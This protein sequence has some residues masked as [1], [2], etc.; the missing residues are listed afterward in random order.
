MR[1]RT[2]VVAVAAA[3]LAG[4]GTAYADG[5]PVAGVT[6]GGQGVSS[7]S[8]RYVAL[9]AP[10]GTAVAQIDESSGTVNGFVSLRG[11]WGIP[12]VAF[13]GATAGISAGG[14]TLVLG[15]NATT[16][17]AKRTRFAL[18]NPLKMRL[19]RIVSLPGAFFFDAISPDG[20]TMYLIQLTSR[21]NLLRY[22]VRA[23]DLGRDRLV[24]GAVVDKTE[25]DERMAGVPMARAATSDGVWAYTLYYK[26]A[27]G[28]FVHALNTQAGVA[29]CI[30]LPPLSTQDTPQ[31]SVDGGRLDVVSEGQVLAAV[32]RTTFAVTRSPAPVPHRSPTPA[33]RRP[34]AGRSSGGAPVWAAI[35]AGLVLAG[36][37][38]LAVRRR[39]PARGGRSGGAAAG[40]P[41]GP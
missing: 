23:Y 41:S 34:A 33:K 6:I 1:I 35:P 38:I 31:L 8:L 40:A 7:G 15:R 25:P 14:Q 10:G 20:G 16:L 13:D 30:D 17:Y 18:V 11:S 29:R 19:R 21:R 9:P 3:V 28:L 27:G 22:A 37:A 12:Q 32:N 26:R 39:R 24:P 5:A 2:A 36:L 4:G